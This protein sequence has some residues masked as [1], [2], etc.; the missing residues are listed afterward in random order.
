MKYIDKSL[1]TYYNHKKIIKLKTRTR[2]VFQN[3]SGSELMMVK[4]QYGFLKEEH[5]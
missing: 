2:R 3:G 1:K 5:L 4:D